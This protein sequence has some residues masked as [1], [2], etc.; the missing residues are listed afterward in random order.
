MRNSEKMFVTPSGWNHTGLEHHSIF[1]CCSAC[2]LPALQLIDTPFHAYSMSFNRSLFLTMLMVEQLSR[3][4]QL[5]GRDLCLL[6]SRQWALAYL[7]NNKDVSTGCHMAMQGVCL[8]LLLSLP[9]NGLFGL[10]PCCPVCFF[11]T[12]NPSASCS[13]CLK[14]MPDPSPESFPCPHMGGSPLCQFK[15]SSYAACCVVRYM[16]RTPFM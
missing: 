13:S 3:R 15:S 1:P 10:P 4:I 16:F 9:W 12:L 11:L 6:L 5:F 2:R 7:C 14:V 8:V